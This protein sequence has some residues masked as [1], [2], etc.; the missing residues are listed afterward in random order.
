MLGIGNA[1]QKSLVKLQQTN[2][3]TNLAIKAKLLPLRPLRTPR[4]PWN[5]PAP[6]SSSTPKPSSTLAPKLGKDGKLTQEERQRHMDNNLCLF[7]S[8]PGHI[9]KECLK[10]TSAGANA[11]AASME[12]TPD[13]SSPAK[14]PKK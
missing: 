10:A 3:R 7:C 2:C 8:K 13:N 9:A 14:E 4:T 5:T 12:K 1:V 6:T 11:R